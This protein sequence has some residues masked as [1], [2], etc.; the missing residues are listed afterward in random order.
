MLRAQSKNRSEARAALSPDSEPPYLETAE[1]EQFDRMEERNAAVNGRQGIT[2]S[3]ESQ[4]EARQRR[5]EERMDAVMEGLSGV[6]RDSLMAVE[7]LLSKNK[8]PCNASRPSENKPEENLVLVCPY[9]GIGGARRALEI[10][11]IT[12]AVYISIDW[13]AESF[14][15]IRAVEERGVSVGRA[16]QLVEVFEAKVSAVT[17]KHLA[18]LLRRPGLNTGLVV[19]GPPC[20]GFSALN[21]NGKGFE[22]PRSQEIRAFAE[23]VRRVKAAGHPGMRWD[24]V[25]ENVSTMAGVDRSMITA[26]LISRA[27]WCREHELAASLVGHINRTRL[28]W[29]TFDIYP[30]EL[31]LEEVD[32][33]PVP[34]RSSAPFAPGEEEYERWYVEHPTKYRR[35]IL[36]DQRPRKP[37]LEELSL[38]HI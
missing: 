37:P 29:I 20:Q 9:D 32:D 36:G 26:L 24:Y 25:M 23:L 22:D 21:R 34:S 2:A 17:S 8:P 3:Q 31:D 30:G 6:S 7:P 14:K 15:V 16:P 1:E 10:L 35:F 12:P 11:G 33:T 38:I 18:P 27:G 28:Y 19:G 5:R 13:N 4:K